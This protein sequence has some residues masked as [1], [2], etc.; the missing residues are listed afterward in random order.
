V[1]ELLPGAR[2]AV[3]TSDTLASPAAAAEFVAQ[4]EGKAIDV[5]VGTQLVTKG[6]SLPELTLVGVID[7]DMGLDGGDL[8]AARTDLPADAPQVAGR[9]GRG[10]KPGEVLIQTRHPKAA[11]IAALAQRGPRRVLRGRN[12]GAARSGCA[13][14]R[15]VGGDHRLERGRGRSAPMPPAPLA[16]RGPTSPVSSS[17]VPPLPRCRCCGRH[18]YRLLIAA[19]RSA[20]VQKIIRAW[21]APLRMPPG[22]RVAVDIDPCSF[23]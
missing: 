17:S 9:A 10:A 14:V 13:A 19:R 12:R 20:E 1:R 7:A 22:V 15:A 2:V 5:I 23:V 6:L 3:V 21:L 18:R 8:R 4:A 16:A 11:V